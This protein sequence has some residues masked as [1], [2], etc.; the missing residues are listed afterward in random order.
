MPAAGKLRCAG[1]RFTMVL[2]GLSQKQLSTGLV[3]E[4]L[5]DR[6]NHWIEPCVSSR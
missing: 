2:R 3:E 6:W 1:H 4:R 5:E